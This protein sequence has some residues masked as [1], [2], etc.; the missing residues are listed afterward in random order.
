M[1]VWVDKHEKPPMPDLV[2]A[3]CDDV[4]MVDDFGADYAVG[5]FLIE[6]KDWA[7][8]A[9][10]ILESDRDLYVQLDELVEAA[11]A[12]DVQPA[13]L[14]EGEIG[15]RLT[16]SKMSP[17]AIAKYLAPIPLMGVTIIP[18]TGRRC[19]A[20]IIGRYEDGNPPDATRVR[21]APKKN[22][23]E[24]R[25][26]IEGFPD[27]GPSTAEKLLDHFGTVRAVVTATEEE[28]QEVDGVGPATSGKIHDVLSRTD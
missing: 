6:R 15:S 9:G 11:E 10:R 18:S 3:A 16:H 28:L 25:F 21:G 26:V 20:D 17:S 7:E 2:R 27:V 23:H 4:R 19:S 14:L 22:G 12:L 8:V 13:L 1:T 5:G 24:R